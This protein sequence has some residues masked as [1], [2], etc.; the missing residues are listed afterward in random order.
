M[1]TGVTPPRAQT[2]APPRPPAPA[3]AAVTTAI[4][5]AT[6]PG[7]DGDAAATLRWDA[8]ETVIGRLAAQ[9]ASVGAA[10]VHVITR[11]EWVASVERALGRRAAAP[12][13]A[14]DPASTLAGGGAPAV[15]VEASPDPSGDLRAIARI[16]RDSGGGLLIAQGEV[17]TQREA[18]AGL[19]ADPRV[20]TGILATVG[21]VGRP[22]QQR[23]RSARG[24]VVSAASPYHGV[25]KPTTTFLG[26][27][28]VAE[29][30]RETLIASAERLAAITA[31]GL[32]EGWDDEIQRKMGIWRAVLARA[33][34]R[35]EMDRESPLEHDVD[36]DN[37]TPE[38]ELPEDPSEIVLSDE[39]EAEIARRGKV[40]PNDVAAMLVVALVRSG[41][42]VGVSHLRKLFWARPITPAGIERARL[43]I[44]EYDEDKVLLDSSVKAADGFFT[45][46][47]VSPYSKYIARWAARRGLTPNQ[48]T[49]ISVL[50]GFAAAAAFATGERWGLITGAVLLQ[51]AFTTDCVDGQ[52]ARYTRQFSKLGAWLDSVFDRTKEYAVFAGLAIGYSATQAGDVWVLAGAALTLQTVRH[53]MDFSFGAARQQVIGETKYPPI[54]QPSDRLG[55]GVAPKPA[56]EVTADAGPEAVDPPRPVSLPRRVLGLWRRL[57]RMPGLIWVKRMVAFPIGERFAVISITAAL[58]DAETTFAVLLAWGGVAATYTFAGRF[59]RSVAR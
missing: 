52:L 57:D 36:D 40:V 58:W 4:L 13:L 42:Q 41:A 54:E 39:D 45:T 8:S 59:L 48:V 15:A 51:I 43:D 12:G 30:D 1:T 11:P 37:D 9:V 27:L 34:W 29:A 7:E 25:T 35:Q 21:R 24:R 26:V 16:A 38:L 46:F 33:A 19:A 2:P 6:A 55:A 14:G 3:P 23:T 20:S 44:Q 28:K 56:R 47:F 18:L 10:S 53:Q 22:F 17:L 32:P 31:D 49:T 50:I 5:L